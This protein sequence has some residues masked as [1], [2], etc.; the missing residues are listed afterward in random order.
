MSKKKEDVIES[1]F[2]FVIRQR[3]IKNREKLK[4]QKYL[5]ETLLLI[6]KLEEKIDGDIVEKNE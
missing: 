1:D 5:N 4:T 3:E 6:K 2:D